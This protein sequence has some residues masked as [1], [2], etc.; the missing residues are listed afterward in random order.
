LAFRV[1]HPPVTLNVGWFGDESLV[2]HNEPPTGVS[3]FLRNV[4]IVRTINT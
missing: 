2:F 1:H 4:F 3:R